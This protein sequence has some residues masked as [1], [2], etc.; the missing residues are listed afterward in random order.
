MAM[1]SIAEAASDAENFVVRAA[2]F[3]FRTIYAVCD[4]SIRNNCIYRS[5]NPTCTEFQP[6]F[7]ALKPPI[8]DIMSISTYE[9]EKRRLDKNLKKQMKLNEK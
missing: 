4:S 5:Q 6:H 7:H 3:C 2:L 8:D 9:Y 1:Y